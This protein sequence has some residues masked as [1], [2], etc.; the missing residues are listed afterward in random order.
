MA[1]SH[2][3]IVSQQSISINQTAGIRCEILGE[4][5][6]TVILNEYYSCKSH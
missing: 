6:V 3:S 4:P 2:C 1:K 5:L